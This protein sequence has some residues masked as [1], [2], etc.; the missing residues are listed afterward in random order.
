MVIIWL[1][2]SQKRPLS[3]PNYTTPVSHEGSPVRGQSSGNLLS[4]P[5]VSA[6]NLTA[7]GRGYNDRSRHVTNERVFFFLLSQVSSTS[8]ASLSSAVKK[9]KAPAPPPLVRES[10]AEAKTPEA[11]E[12]NGHAD[13]DATSGVSDESVSDVSAPS[14]KRSPSPEEDAKQPVSRRVSSTSTPGELDE[15]QKWNR[16][17]IELGEVLCSQIQQQQQRASYRMTAL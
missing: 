17:L 3:T 15:S 9:R 6:T 14:S 16:F 11:R 13:S 2:R 4:T 8:D 12:T 5:R 7:V 1:D 10:Q